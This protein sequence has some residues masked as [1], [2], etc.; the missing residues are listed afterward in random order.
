MSS[1]IVPLSGGGTYPL[2]SGRLDSL[3][4]DIISLVFTNLPLRSHHD[5]FLTCRRFGVVARLPASRIHFC[6]PYTEVKDCI[7]KVGDV[8]RYQGLLDTFDVSSCSRESLLASLDEI[9][10]R[11]RV[12]HRLLLPGTE[13]SYSDELLSWLRKVPEILLPQEVQVAPRFLELDNL[14]TLSYY[15]FP[16]SDFIHLPTSLRDLHL[17]LTIDAPQPLRVDDAGW[18]H[19]THSLTRLRQLELL[20]LQVHWDDS[21]WLSLKRLT[22]LHTLKISIISPTSISSS[23]SSSSSTSTSPSTSLVVDMDTIVLPALRYLEMDWTHVKIDQCPTS[24]EWQKWGRW[25]PHVEELECEGFCNLPD[26]STWRRLCTFRCQLGGKLEMDVSTATRW[27][28]SLSTFTL[29]G[30]YI[31]KVFARW[32]VYIT[33]FG[34]H[35]THLSLLYIR[36]TQEEWEIL[37]RGLPHLRSLSLLGYGVDLHTFPVLIHHFSGI[38]RF[39]VQEQTVFHMDIYPLMAKLTALVELEWCCDDFNGTVLTEFARWC[40]RSVRSLTTSSHALTGEDVL[41]TL[42]VLPPRLQH[43]YLERGMFHFSPSQRLTI[44]SSTCTLHYSYNL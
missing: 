23:S 8:L 14:V 10:R 39:V 31:G 1:P 19:V 28:L 11:D 36:Q 9:R 4:D 44:D 16:L 22:F 21:W 3:D 24:Y 33:L 27:P 37:G 18:R 17:Y 30:C 20:C 5:L 32:S 42:S 29:G 15:D 35:L 7:K 13:F 12:P 38:H 41:R 6:V 2:R 26:I 43:W 40:P 25:M 34:P